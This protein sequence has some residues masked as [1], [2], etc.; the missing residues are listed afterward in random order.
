DTTLTEAT[1]TAIRDY[2]ASPQLIVQLKAPSN[3]ALLDYINEN[4][5]PLI[6]IFEKEELDRALSGN[7]KYRQAGLG[8]EIKEMFGI[9]IDLPN[10]YRKRNTV[11]NDFMWVSYEYPLASQG[12]AIYTYPYSGREDFL[13][14]SMLAR[15]NEFMKRIP[16][17]SDGS[18]MTTQDMF[19]PEVK[20]MTINGREWA[21]MR[22]FWDIENDFMGGPAVTYSTRDMMN[23]RIVV[24]DCYVYHP[25]GDKRNYMR[26]LEA[27]VH[28][29]RLE[30]DTPVVTN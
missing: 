10:G 22:S 30:E 6:D 13:M 24:I 12:F 20:Y 7:K 19:P 18:Y 9:T 15:R 25:D 2:W 1:S 21:E 26:G 5:Q 23:N 17:P 3:Q 14:E 4:R 16:G 28:S 27:V 11:G 29:V 8:S